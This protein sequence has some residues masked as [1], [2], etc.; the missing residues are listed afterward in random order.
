MTFQYTSLKPLYCTG[1]HRLLKSARHQRSTSMRTK[2]ETE[3]SF[4]RKKKEISYHGINEKYT[5]RGNQ[6]RLVRQTYASNCGYFN[7]TIINL[8][9]YKLY[10]KNK[11]N[12]NV[13]YTRCII[14]KLYDT[15]L[16]HML[17]GI[18][19]TGVKKRQQ[20][21]AWVN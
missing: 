7:K 14:S 5:G 16:F 15:V 8:S 4:Q 21:K 20:K 3:R 11:Q 2:N 17:N 13:S 1:S 19:F 6:N 10:G 9:Y 18:Q 12:T